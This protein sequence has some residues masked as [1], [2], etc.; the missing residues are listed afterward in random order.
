MIQHAKL[1]ALGQMASGIAHDF[2]NALV[3]ILGFSEL[4]LSRPD[5]L[6]D[7]EKSRNYLEMIRMGAEDAAS[8]VSRMQEFYRRRDEDEEFL[9][10]HLET[11]VSQAVT[12]TQ[13]RWKDQ[14]QANGIT[15]TVETELGDADP[16]SGSESELREAVTNLILN[17][18]D[19]MPDGGRILLQTRGDDE[20]VVLDVSDSGTGMADE[21]R[22]RC[23][24]P[25]FTTKGVEGTGMGLAMVHGIVQ[26]H[27]G[28]IDIE[29]VEGQGTRFLIRLPVA[30]SSL[31]SRNV[32]ER[33]TKD[34][35]VLRILAVDDEPL[36]LQVLS[37]LLK[38]DG[39]LVETAANGREGLES[40]KRGSFDIVLIDWAMPEMGGDQLAVSIKEEAPNT[41]I[42][43]LSGFGDIIKA[44]G[45][46]PPGV[47]M[48]VSKPA[49]L[50]EV[51]HA[52][53]SL[54]ARYR[55]PR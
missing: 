19:A 24:E 35:N 49:K 45:E 8:V 36:A 5:N 46:M 38:G 43:L 52:V 31:Q 30:H 28:S 44:T 37:E 13:P 48:V 10:V 3:P 33:D 20:Y 40:F 27:E 18:V 47:D 9:P 7:V 34:G 4:L 54:L 15:I 26:R 25:F 17:A 11:V 22:T 55:Q 53:T 50:D 21:V 2:N 42:V 39:H 14:V 12:L 6:T 29:S 1:S 41:P 32:V 16:V 51:R 23:M